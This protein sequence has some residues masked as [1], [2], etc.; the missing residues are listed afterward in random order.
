MTNRFTASALI[1]SAAAAAL[2]LT[3]C[4]AGENQPAAEAAADTTDSGDTAALTQGG[5]L[6]IDFATYNPLS[7]VIKDQGWLE[8]AL[9]DQ[10][11]TVNWVQSAGS[12]KANQALLADAIDVGSTAGSAALLARSN[13][14]PIQVI[15]IYS[16]PEWSALVVPEGSAIG[17]VEDLKGKQVAATKGTDP[18]FFLLQALEEA[19]LS[20]TDIT[21]QNLQH[22]DGWA[23]L[24]NGSVD[25]WAGL[26]PI[27]GGA[28]AAG[29]E[30]VYRNVDFNSYGFLNA[31][32]SFIA[33]KP[34]VAQTVVDV[35]EHARAWALENEEETVAI[36][37]EVAALDPAVAATVITER[38]NLDVDNVPGDAQLDV[39]TTIGPVF[40][41]TGDVLDQSQVDDALDTI[42][43][44]TFAT[45][46]DP[47][48]VE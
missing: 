22:A 45:N 34:D 41:E 39:L 18:Y 8:D 26:D 42:I 20:E 15:D 43:N 28:E 31:T 19:G 24:Q 27:M 48:I 16:Q 1:A 40:V 10:D 47:S 14:S 7:L 21:V 9:A 38:S 12:N 30:L 13:G 2:L 5:E 46:A 33:E 37:A 44:D 3:G 17:S 29:A 32:E 25:A 36:L 11:I 23:A 6:N 4:V 35:Y